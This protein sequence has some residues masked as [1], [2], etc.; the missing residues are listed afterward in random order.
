MIFS[1]EQLKSLID[2]EMIG[3]QYPYNTN[4]EQAVLDYL[5]MIRAEFNRMPNLYCEPD[6]LH[7]G[8][9]YAS[10][11]EWFFYTENE[12]KAEEKNGLRTIEK[13]GLVVDISL[14]SPVLL[15]GTGEKFAT[16]CIETGDNIGG[17]KTF[18]FQ[19]LDLEIPEKFSTLKS[20]IERTF[21][22]H[23]YT[24][25]QKEDVAPHLPFKAQIPTLH[26]DPQEYLIWDAIFYWED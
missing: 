12:V 22:K 21:M 7:F 5:K 26:R 13:E 16:L 25:L 3:E 6:R 19:S 1:N 4:N 10:Y 11:V 18:F 20:N 17:G 9:G 8:S 23:H 2:G 24:I 15:I 14:L